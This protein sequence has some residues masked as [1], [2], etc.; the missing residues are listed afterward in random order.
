MQGRH[1]ASQLGGLY[2]ELQAQDTEILVI[3]GGNQSD[4]AK[5]KKSLTLPCPVLADSDREVYLSYGLDKA[6]WV[7]QWSASLSI[8]K[9]GNV[10][11]FHK[12]TNP[13]TDYYPVYNF[14]QH[15]RNLSKRRS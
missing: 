11:Y 1:H 12:A 4:A 3:G 9:Q 5:S 10:R 13:Y 6:M 8:H 15:P 14:T 7:I 2:D